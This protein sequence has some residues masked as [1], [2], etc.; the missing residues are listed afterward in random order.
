MKKKSNGS[1]LNGPSKMLP[2][3]HR[4][5]LDLRLA[6]LPPPP[7]FD[8]LSLCVYNVLSNEHT[9][10]RE[11]R[12]KFGMRKLGGSGPIDICSRS[13]QLPHSLLMVED[14]LVFIHVQAGL[15]GLYVV[16]NRPYYCG[17]LLQ[18]LKGWF[19]DLRGISWLRVNDQ[20]R[21]FGGGGMIRN[22]FRGRGL[23][24]YFFRWKYFKP[25]S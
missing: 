8:R 2:A 7:L 5:E 24:F 15:A 23:R 17:Q 12:N 9:L 22:S 10:H 14:L 6:L 13:S 25:V 4:I 3:T 21:H 16:C 18:T 1:L 20:R 19:F 11:T